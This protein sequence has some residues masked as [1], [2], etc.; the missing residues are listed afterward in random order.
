MTTLRIK[1]K[2]IAVLV[3]AAALVAAAATTASAGRGGSHSR[4]KNAINTGS[5]AAIV[6]EL[7]RAER[8][9]CS[10]ACIET[11]MSLLDHPEYEVREAAGWWFA[12]RPAQMN[13]L[14]D[15]A[16]A[17]LA[18][19]DTVAARNAADALGAFRRTGAVPAL[20]AAAQRSDLGAEARLA[21][22]RALG[23]I[24]HL[25]A[26]PALSAAMSDADADVRLTA[27]EAWRAVHG[28]AGAAPVIA[29]LSDDDVRVRREAAAV[30]GSLREAG[31]RT[32]LEAMLAGDDDSI[33]RRSAAWALGRIGDPASRDVLDAATSD[34]S[35]LVRAT[36]KAALRKLR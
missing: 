8:L 29:L 32:A 6:A 18:G 24:G 30:A 31:A 7:E 17:Q 27:V 5:S 1:T 20:S 22:V 33:A 10:S 14:R 35:S 25:D 26:N 11:V 4:I 28:Q 9:I 3:G 12:R 23:L 36:A 21:A 19:D 13:E 2:M 15:Q 34:D 16:L